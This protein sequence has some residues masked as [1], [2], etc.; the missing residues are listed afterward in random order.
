M[1]VTTTLP[2]DVAAGVPVLEWDEPAPQ[3]IEG[4]PAY[5]QPNHRWYGACRRL[6]RVLQQLVGNLPDY[7]RY[8]KD[9]HDVSWCQEF[10]GLLDAGN[11]EAW[12]CRKIIRDHFV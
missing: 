7:E 2:A 10:V 4:L 9:E 11:D 3:I 1:N 5:D 12:A 6:K 8:L